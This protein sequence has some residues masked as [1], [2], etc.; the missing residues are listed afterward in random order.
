MESFL[1]S[2]GS[3]TKCNYLISGFTRKIHSYLNSSIFSIY[4][5]IPNDINL[6]CLS[7]YYQHDQFDKNNIGKDIVLSNDA[8]TV[9]MN[10]YSKNNSAFLSRIVS[11]GIHR[12]VFV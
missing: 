5:D 11:S 2:E 6:L 10:S 7:Y 3:K 4:R 1:F 9:T 12:L 8:Y